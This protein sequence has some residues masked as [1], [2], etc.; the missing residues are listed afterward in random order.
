MIKMLN[1]E[2]SLPSE[3]PIPAFDK[4]IDRNI[5]VQLG[6]TAY[7]PCKI[8][9]LGNNTVAWI[10][11]RDSHIIST[12]RDVFI[13][14]DRFS[15]LHNAATETWTLSIKYVQARD[16]GSYE[17]QVST[18]PKSSIFVTLA[19][20]V[21]KV[22]IFGNKEIHVKAG[23]QV[24]LKCIVSQAVSHPPFVT[25]YHDGQMVVSTN[26]R[27]PVLEKKSRDTII[28]SFTIKRAVKS[29]EGNYTCQPAN[30]HTAT[31]RLHVINGELSE[32]SIQSGHATFTSQHHCILFAIFFIFRIGQ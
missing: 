28:S 8:K 2:P 6:G 5:T 20:V 25:W 17:C 12:D 14:D 18:V 9:N 16:A 22:R 21:P 3:D 23:S 29:D 19:V 10:R 15:S 27:S 32:P 11:N 4:S 7:L 26:R 13:V 1:T 31:V 30:L 24:Q